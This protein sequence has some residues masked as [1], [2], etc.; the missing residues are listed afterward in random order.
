[1]R[2]DKPM[3]AIPTNV[4]PAFLVCG[5]ILSEC[6]ADST[7]LALGGGTVLAGRWAHRLSTDLDFFVHADPA[8]IPALVARASDWTSI[9][10]LKTLP[11]DRGI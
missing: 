3:F 6:F 9:R 8:R 2:N 5:P 7:T 4:E 1:M 10:L 11:P